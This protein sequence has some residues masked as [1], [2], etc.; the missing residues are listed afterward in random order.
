MKYKIEDFFAALDERHTPEVRKKLW[1]ARVGIAGIG[2]LGSNT[3][4][5]LARAGVGHIHIVDDDEVDLPNINRQAY[6]LRHVG[7]KKT[8]ALTEIIHDI[9]PYIEVISDCVRVS[10]ETIAQIFEKDP[11]ICEAFDKAENKAA[12]TN[13]VLTSLPDAVLVSGIGMAGYS[14]T[15]LIRTRRIMDRFYV[16]GDETNGL[17]SGQQLMAPR[18]TAC[19]A[20]QANMVI[21]LILSGRLRQEQSADIRNREQ[22]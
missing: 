15:N 11:I 22:E 1:N 17:E 2:G 13:G 21:Q 4:A 12:F 20:H 6:F 9:N 8:D 19:S 3:A 7:W 16:C 10:E 5:A 18:V 14:D